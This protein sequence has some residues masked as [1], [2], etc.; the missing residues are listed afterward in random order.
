MVASEQ[1]T[2]FLEALSY[3]THSVRGAVFVEMDIALGWEGTIVGVDVPAGEDVGGG[4]GGGLLDAPEEEDGVL[5]GDEE[6]A[7]VGRRGGR[8]DAG[9]EGV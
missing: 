1:Y 6:D 4:E 3:C 9:V 5:G 2:A 7:V 8:S